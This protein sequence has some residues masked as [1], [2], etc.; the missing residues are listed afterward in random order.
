MIRD[1][2]FGY[3]VRVI[4][5]VEDQSADLALAQVDIQVE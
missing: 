5:R 4:P 1:E 2:G 3:R